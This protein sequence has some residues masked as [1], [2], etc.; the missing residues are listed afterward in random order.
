M[1]VWSS[2]QGIDI[3]REEEEEDYELPETGKDALIVVLDV[4]KNMFESPSKAQDK[5]VEN[6][7]EDMEEDQESSTWFHEC[8]KLLIKMLKSKIIAND[9]SLLSIVFFGTVSIK[10]NHKVYSLDI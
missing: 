7:D 1:D 2:G 10:K 9:N 4:R 3:K 8:I 5:E 6:E